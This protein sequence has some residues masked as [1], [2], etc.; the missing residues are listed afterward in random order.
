MEQYETEIL[1]PGPDKAVAGRDTLEAAGLVTKYQ[2][3]IL[4][5]EGNSGPKR[6]SGHLPLR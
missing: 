5:L 1:E 3:N 4:C 2:V 6:V